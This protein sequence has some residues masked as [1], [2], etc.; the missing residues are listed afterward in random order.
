MKFRFNVLASL[1]VVAAFGLAACQPKNTAPEGT[2]TKSEAN[3]SSTFNFNLPGDWQECFHEVCFKP[4]GTLRG[5][6]AQSNY[7]FIKWYPSDD[8]TKL[9]FL[10][11]GS[12]KDPDTVKVR[13]C[14]YGLDGFSITKQDISIPS[15][16][17]FEPDEVVNADVYKAHVSEE[18]V[19]DTIPKSKLPWEYQ[20]LPARYRK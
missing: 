14:E 7:T 6:Y 17:P 10:T 11:Y 1:L 20:P 16:F 3:L 18:C 15:M 2:L 19:N 12:G 9:L 13:M 5:N 8:K 4:N